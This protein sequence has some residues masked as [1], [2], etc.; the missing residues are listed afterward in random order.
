MEEHWKSLL[1]TMT[2]MKL[3]ADQWQNHGACM[4]TGIG[5]IVKNPE[6]YCS[7]TLAM[8][9]L[10]QGD[11]LANLMASSQEK[12]TP[13]KPYKAETL[14]DSLKRITGS[15]IGIQCS[16]GK[17]GDQY[18]TEVH[19]YVDSEGKGGSKDQPIRS[20]CKPNMIFF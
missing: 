10:Y 3:W 1:P 14:T 4:A 15:G 20:N 9:F 12:V 18:L 2:D 7:A 16:D 13:G 19:I 11:N 17:D 6:Y 5:G 8:F